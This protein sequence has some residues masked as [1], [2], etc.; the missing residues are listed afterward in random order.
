MKIQ[1]ISAS[2]HQFP[3]VPPLLT[4]PIEHR[5]VVFC[6]V[7][8]EDGTVGHGLTGHFLP[9]AVVTALEKEFLPVVRG[10][11]VRDVERIHQTVWTR[12]NPR[13]MTGVISSALSCLDIACWDIHGKATGRTIA[14]LL[15]GARD[16]VASYITFGFPEYDPDQLVQAAKDQVKAG[17]RR[18]KMVVGVTELG[19]LED[20]RRVR[21]VRE[22]IGDDVE[23]MIDANY[24]FSPVEAFI[25]ARAVEDCHLTWFEEPLH[26]N[27]ARAMADLRRRVQIPL[28]G[29][30]MEG[31]RWRFRELVD[32]QA[33]DIL[34]PNACYCGGYTEARKAAHLAQAFNLPIANGGGWPRFN[35]HT[36]A[37]LMNGWRVEFHLGMKFVE[38]QIFTDAPD[39]DPVTNT[40]RIPSAPG[41]GMQVNR[42][43]LRDSVMTA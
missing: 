19:P 2:V 29:G 28:S 27:D 15:G 37:G 25:L 13:A 14:Q 30:Q 10:M 43:A 20:A 21:A 5:K 41:L 38:E 34:Q 6:E 32:N 35:M 4:E 16:E 1:R 39:P 23:L 7:E 22:A 33:V 3:I 11:D 17:F 24:M 31:H 8:T 36:M 9:F 12:L 40:V 42:D 26:Q 18:L